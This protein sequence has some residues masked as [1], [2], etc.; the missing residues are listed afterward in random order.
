MMQME[1]T[2]KK[3]EIRWYQNLQG[4]GEDCILEQLSSINIGQVSTGNPKVGIY[5]F[6]NNEETGTLEKVLLEGAN[7]SYPELV[8]E[9]T[10]YID[11][12]D[13]KYKKK[14]KPS[15]SQKVLVGCIANILKPGKANQVSIQDNDW[16]CGKSLENGSQFILNDFIKQILGRT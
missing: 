10:S 3:R 12:I 11:N 5:V 2:Q 9:A 6:P 15:D 8:K 14:W 16:I 7:Q 1:R 4:I 13:D